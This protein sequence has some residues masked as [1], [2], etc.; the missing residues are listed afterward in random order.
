MMLFFY[1]RENCYFSG[2]GIY[3]FTLHEAICNFI[4]LFILVRKVVEIHL[5]HF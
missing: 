3:R 5:T 1:S 4:K 2:F